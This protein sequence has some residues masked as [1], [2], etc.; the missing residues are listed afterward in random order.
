MNWINLSNM[1]LIRQLIHY[2]QDRPKEKEEKETLLN[3]LYESLLK[4][5]R[6]SLIKLCEHAYNTGRYDENDSNDPDL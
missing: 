6:I 2:W 1:D 3:E 5:Q 4:E